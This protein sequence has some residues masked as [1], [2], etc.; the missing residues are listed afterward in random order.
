[1]HGCEIIRV[2]CLDEED[3]KAIKEIKSKIHIPIVADIHFDYKIALTAIEAGVDKLRINPGNIGGR[4]RV[5]A[6][7]NACRVKNIPIRIGVNSGSIEQEILDK[8]NGRPTA[9]GMVES[10][11]KHIKILE[12]LDFYDICV[13]LKATNLELCIEAYEKASESFDYPLHIG[14]TEA[15]NSI[16]WSNKIEYRIGSFI[17]RRN[18]GYLESIFIR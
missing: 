4:D 6:V 12:E 17:K 9:E 18:R 1:M 11:I 2:A 5:E 16:F 7:V 15:R 13:S 8:Y 3:A 14:I 10:A